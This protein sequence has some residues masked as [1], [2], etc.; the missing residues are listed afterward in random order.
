MLLGRNPHGEQKLKVFYE[1][2][3]RIKKKS[4]RCPIMF[5]LEEI[6]RLWI[7]VLSRYLR[8]QRTSFNTFRWQKG[9]A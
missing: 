2:E 5:S 1:M 3:D 8:S 9:I 7:D 6:L 4:V